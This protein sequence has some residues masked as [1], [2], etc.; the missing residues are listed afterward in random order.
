M[1]T[2]DPNQVAAEVCSSLPLQTTLEH[3]FCTQVHFEA[4]E[5]K[6]SK[7]ETSKM[8][9]FDPSGF[10]KG[11]VFFLFFPTNVACKTRYYNCLLFV[12]EFT[13]KCLLE[14]S[15]VCSLSSFCTYCTQSSS[16]FKQKITCQQ[17]ILTAQFGIK[18]CRT[19]NM[20]MTRKR[21]VRN[22]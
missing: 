16:V 7:H 17:S 11:W 13:N 2:A 15:S 9:T 6:G 5:K 8:R 1:S 21:G 20:T 19:P 14:F 22:D 12:I 4:D 3:F 18:S 10:L